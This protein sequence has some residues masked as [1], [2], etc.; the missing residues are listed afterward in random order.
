MIKFSRHIELLL[1]EH[2]CVIVPGLGGFIANHMEARY[3]KEGDNTFLPPYR[4]VMY[5]QQLQVNDGLLVQSYMSAYDASYPAAYLQMEKE[6]AQVVNTLEMSGEY[7]IENVGVLRKG[8]GKNITFKA[9][10]TGILTPRLFGLSNMEMPSLSSIIANN[11]AQAMINQASIYVAEDEQNEESKPLI[12]RDEL[13]KHIQ[14]VADDAKKKNT[15]E[16]VIRIN[17]R[18]VDFSISA[19]AAII[20]FFCLSYSAMKGISTDTD[21]V[22]AALCPLPNKVRVSVETEKRGH[23]TASELFNSNHKASNKK[24]TSTNI[25][26]SSTD[27]ATAT[28]TSAKQNTGKEKLTPAN[29]ATQNNASYTIVLASYVGRENAEIFINQLSAKG[30]P[31]AE[32]KKVGKVNR[33]LYSGYQTEEEAQTALST[34]RSECSDFAEAW[35]FHL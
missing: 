30:Y 3:D 31:K 11:K 6:I 23:K 7:C 4:T 19:A 26:S 5:N 17:K 25:A 12:N 22:I 13:D 32:F 18:L 33:I 10:E 24:A 29:A 34:L 27:P 15:K 16:V 1:L 35:I 14:H 21:T 8:I 2:D 9:L 28:S 20:L